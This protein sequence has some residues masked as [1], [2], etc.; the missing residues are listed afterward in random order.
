M[1]RPAMAKTIFKKKS[2]MRVITL[3][4]IQ[5]TAITTVQN[6]QRDTHKDKWSIN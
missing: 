6:Q 3:T 5:A 2:K 1:E 4:G